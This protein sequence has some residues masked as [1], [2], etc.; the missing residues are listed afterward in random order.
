MKLKKI[1]EVLE[2]LEKV[3]LERT[4]YGFI[5]GIIE[6]NSGKMTVDG[7]NI[8]SKLFE[9]QKN[10]GYVSQSIY[11]NDDSIMENVVLAEKMKI[12]KTN[13]LLIVKNHKFVGSRKK[14]T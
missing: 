2:L 9:W 1:N 7:L 3:V 13:I 10:I 11:L 4:N 12:L 5:M 14:F 8:K 6:P